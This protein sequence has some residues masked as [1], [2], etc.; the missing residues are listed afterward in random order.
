MNQD[1]NIAK[2]IDDDDDDKNNNDIISNGNET[3]IIGL[4]QVSDQEAMIII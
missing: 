1:T 2:Y 4:D 3:K